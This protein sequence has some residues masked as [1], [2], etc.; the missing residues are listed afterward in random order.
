MESA[1]QIQGPSFLND[2][3]NAPADRFDIAAKVPAGAT[4]EQVPLMLRALLVERFH[5]SLH[6]ETRTM[7]IYALEVA[8]NGLKMKESPQEVAEGA[9]GEARCTR[10][11]AEHEGAT[12]AAACTHLTSADIAQQVQALAPGYFRDGPVVDMSGLNGVYDLK[13]EWTTAIEVNNGSAGLTMLDA[14]QDQLG[15]KPERRRQP[16]EV[17]VVDKLDQMPTEN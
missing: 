12:L 3:F 14:V 2:T 6:Q 9:Q 10:S 17:L 11:F 16:M 4:P 8:K 13:L 7:Q 15:L 1:R 5:L